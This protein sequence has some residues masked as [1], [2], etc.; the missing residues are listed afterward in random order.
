MAR[1]SSC[2][3]AMRSLLPEMKRGAE[4]RAANRCARSAMTVRCGNTAEIWNERM[5]PRR[6]ICAGR[7]RVMSVPLKTIWPAV[8]SRNLVSRL[9]QVVLP[10]PF[11][12]ISAWIEPRRTRRFTPFTAMK[13]LNSLVRPRVSRIVSP[14]IMFPSMRSEALSNMLVRA[15][16]WFGSRDPNL[17]TSGSSVLAAIACCTN[18][19]R[20]KPGMHWL[21]AIVAPMM[22]RNHRDLH[23]VNAWRVRAS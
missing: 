17:M 22:Q 2:I 6:A 8:G 4:L 14:R 15:L 10:A 11:G 12:P 19:A 21:D 7:S 3:A 9:K 23:L 16:F 20:D 13:P 5:T 1:S 18:N